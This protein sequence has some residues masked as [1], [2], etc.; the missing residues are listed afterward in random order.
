MQI[1]VISPVYGAS[2]LLEKLVTEIEETVK[3]LTDDYEIILV[4]DHSPDES[5]A[6]IE[7]ICASNTKVKGILLSRNFGQQYALNA[8]LDAASGDWIV[9]LDCDL[10]DTPAFIKQLFEKAQEGYDVVFASRQHRQDGFVKKAGSKF[11]NGLLGFLTD[12]V[13]DESIA[14]FVL[15]KREVVD[16][17]KTMGDYRR[18]YPL[19]N[20]WVGFNSVKLPVPHAERQDGR[21]SSYSLRK[22]IKLAINTSVAFSNKALNIIVYVGAVLMI[23]SM[24]VGLVLIIKYVFA[25]ITVSGWL[26]LFVSVWFIAG[27]LMLILGVISLYIGEMY[28]QTKNRPSY[29]VKRRINF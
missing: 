8:G 6:V 13:Q 22:R 23:I 12:T 26:T 18:Y 27:L 2:S 24:V 11:F 25:G 16:A 28:V 20:H 17:M 19:M 15:Y 4:E 7:R 9:T 3:G 10:Q 29:L 1:S 14:N 21:S 5:A